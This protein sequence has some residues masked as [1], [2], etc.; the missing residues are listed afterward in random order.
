MELLLRKGAG[1][2]VLS[3]DGSSPMHLAAACGHTESCEL[4]LK[5]G[6]Q[7]NVQ[8]NKGDTPLHRAAVNGHMTLCQG[9]KIVIFCL[10]IFAPNCDFILII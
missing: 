2:Q 9:L 1:V 3:K 6:A 5:H 7:L 4:L 10:N 8:D